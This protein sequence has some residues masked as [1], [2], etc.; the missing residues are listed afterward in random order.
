MIDEYYI[1]DKEY[2]TFYENLNNLRF[3][4]VSDL[5]IRSSVNILDI[6]SGYG[7]FTI[8]VAKHDANLQVTGIDI[9]EQAVRKARKNIKLHNLQKRVRIIEM[10]ATRMQ[11]GKKSFDMAVSF[12]GF[13]DIHM[14]RGRKGVHATFSQVNAV[15]KPHSFFCL[16]VMP[17][18]E[19]ETVAQ[20]TEVDLYS[21]IC[22]ATW[23]R[24]RVY[25]KM[26]EQA[27]FKLIRRKEYYTGKKL[28]ANQAKLEIKYA[29]KNVP[30]IYGIDTPTFADIWRKFG[31]KIEEQGLGQYSKVVLIVAQKRKDLQ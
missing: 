20:K 30:Q 4:V 18:D 6:G 17:T 8:E 21:Y 3:R 11:F 22:D 10:D 25:K 9:S 7:Y 5:P 27:G 14:T 26:L 1:S 15:L 13:E 12:T 31:K 19:M 24:S 2:R 16:V 23:L 28:T 29:C